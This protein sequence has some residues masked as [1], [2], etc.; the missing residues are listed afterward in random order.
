M[1][2]FVTG[3]SGFV[4]GRLVETLDARGDDVV[5]LARSYHAESEVERRGAECVRGDLSD[6]DAMADGMRGCDTVFHAAAKVG[7]WGPREEFERINVRGTENVVEAAW[8]AGVDRLVHVSTEAVLMDGS[9]LEHVDES[10]PIPEDH[11]GPYAATKAE[12]ERHVLDANSEELTTVAVRPRFVWGRGDTTLLPELAEAVEEGS[13]FWFGGGRYST[14]TCH[15]ANAVEGML[16]AAEHGTGGR[17]YFLSDGEPV[18]FRGFVSELLETQ[19]VDPP[20][21]SMPRWLASAVASAAERACRILPGDREPPLTRAT[22]A[23]IGRE[24]TVDDSRAREE[25]GY[26][27]HVSRPEGIADLRRAEDVRERKQRYEERRQ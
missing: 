4:G 5:A 27:A 22:L 15:V 3:G 7:Q 26:R 13:F 2:A 17:A 12:A 19:G 6:T 16:L 14:S 25:L 21:R 8:R 10:T 23:L 11:V 20:D 9:P 1:Q 18:E 24:V